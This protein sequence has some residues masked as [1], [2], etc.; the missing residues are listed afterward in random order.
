MAMAKIPKDMVER[1]KRQMRHFNEWI[2]GDGP[3]PD[4]VSNDPTLP[5]HVLQKT[6]PIEL[7]SLQI[8][9]QQLQRH[10][11]EFFDVIERIEAQRDEWRDI[12]KDSVGKYHT[13]LGMLERELRLERV[14]TARLLVAFNTMR[15]EK[16]LEPIHTPR[17]LDRELGIDAHPVG[18]AAQYQEAIDELLLRGAPDQRKK[19]KGAERPADID[20]KAE[21]AAIV[22]EQENRDEP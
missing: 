1:F 21:R 11:D 4:W 3:Q 12:V 22:S 9:C 16:K 20:G 18:L 17:Y 5:Q 19:R 10:K 6:R 13:A 8:K 14:R 2:A 15:E 7:E